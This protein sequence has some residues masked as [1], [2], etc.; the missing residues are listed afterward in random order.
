[1]SL[2]QSWDHWKFRLGWDKKPCWQNY[3]KS[4]KRRT[5]WKVHL[6]QETMSPADKLNYF[7]NIHIYKRIQI[8]LPV[9]S[10]FLMIWSK[11]DPILDKNVIR[12]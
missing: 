2:S 3:S 5:H 10:I 6:L 12:V 1:M 4:C 11:P 9:S 7:Q 8:L